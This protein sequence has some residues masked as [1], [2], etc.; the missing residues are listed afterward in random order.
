MSEYLV[1][2]LDSFINYIQFLANN[3]GHFH[4]II[5]RFAIQ[6]SHATVDL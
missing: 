1:H 3:V 6:V 5:A 4:L 2:L